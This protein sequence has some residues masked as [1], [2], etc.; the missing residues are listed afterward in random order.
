MDWP[1]HLIVIMRAGEAPEHVPAHIDVLVGAA[2]SASRVDGGAFDRAI[3][4]YGGGGRTRRVFHAKQ[5]L[6][7]IGAQHANYNDQE[8]SLG[9]SR[10]YSLQIADPGHSLDLLAALRD[11]ATVE[12]ARVQTLATVPMAAPTLAAVDREAALEPHERIEAP[13][14]HKIEPGDERITTAVVDTGII[15]GHPE[16]QRK[17]LAGYDTVDLGLGRLNSNLRLEGDSRGH[18]YNPHDDVG[19]GCHVAGIVG[20]QGWNIPR[21]VCGLSLLLAVRVL[22]AAVADGSTKR[23]GVGGI[24]DIDCGLKVAVDLGADVINMSFGTPASS[25]DPNAPQPHQEVVRYAIQNGCVLVAAAGNSGMEEKYYPA[26]LPEV[27]AVSS[28]NSE[29]R[30]SSFSTWG[31][32]ISLCAPGERIVSTARRGYAVNSGTSF[33]APFVSGVAALMLA[34]AKRAGVALGGQLVKALLCS[35]AKPIGKGFSPETGHGFLNAVA[36]LRAVDEH[37]RRARA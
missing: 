24:A 29:N 26:A 21:G 30:R 16:F 8:E 15:V 32:H 35:S 4:R 7:R 2:R 36:A 13:A 31:S 23:V 6:G 22:A 9:L 25:A 34:R 12:S 33:A 18:D 3:A 20:A 19:H 28:V 5:S 11:L 14:A 27:I 10:T 17:C 1:G 37:L